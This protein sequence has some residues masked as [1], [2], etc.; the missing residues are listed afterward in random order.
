[1]PL[2][3]QQNPF[4]PGHRTNESLDPP[5][6]PFHQ[7]VLIIGIRFVRYIYLYSS[8][9]YFQL[10]D[11]DFLALL[12]FPTR[13]LDGFLQTFNMSVYYDTTTCHGIWTIHEEEMGVE[14]PQMAK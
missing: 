10:L 11:Y 3:E 14:G 4:N 9:A 1:M 6:C 2:L 12:P 8:D 5:N 13:I 7:S